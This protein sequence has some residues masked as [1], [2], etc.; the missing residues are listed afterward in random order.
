MIP[1]CRPYRMGVDRFVACTACRATVN[2]LT[3][4]LRE[5]YKSEYDEIFKSTAMD[6]CDRL[7][8]QTPE[9]CS[10]MIDL[11]MPS[12]KYIIENSK[13]DAS[14]FC[15]LFMELNFCQV[16]DV[17]YNWTLNVD[18]G[19]E[20]V[21]A[22]KSE[23]PIKNGNELR[24]LH[25]TDIHYDPLYEP[26][27]LAECDEPQCCQR[28]GGSTESGKAAGYWGDY[29]G[30]DSP[31]HMIVDALKHIKNTHSY[32]DYIYQTGDVVDHMTWATSVE[33]NT[34]VLS[35]VN[36]LLAEV[37]PGVPVYSCVGN[38]EAH[39][40]NLFSPDDVSKEV[41]TH[42]L[43]EHL[44]EDWSEWLPNDTKNTI[45]AG[46][47]YTVTPKPGFRVIALNN[48]D[49][50]TENWWLFYDGTNKIPQLQWLHDTLLAAEKASE[51]VHILEHIQTGDETCWSVW[52]REFNRLVERFRYT[53]SGI[54]NGHSHRDEMHLHYS[55][56]G[57]AIGV[58]WNGGALTTSSSKNPN[59]RIYQLEHKTLQVVDSETWIFNLTE[60][61]AHGE[62]QTPNWSKEYEFSAEFTTDLSPE[63]MDKLLDKMADNPKLLR[64]FWRYK[65]T[66]ADPQLN[67]GCNRNCL[68]NTIC[69]IAITVNNQKTR[70]EQLKAKLSI[71]LANEGTTS[72][73]TSSTTT[74]SAKTTTEES[75]NTT[76]R[77][78]DDAAPCLNISILILIVDGV[79][80]VLQIAEL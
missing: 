72:S 65:V 19:G 24:I 28:G 64:K 43:Y 57:H 76:D 26:G 80:L 8:L 32:I 60:A 47:Y 9:V 1:F 68:L 17:N 55:S 31:W 73:I 58:T 49:C 41:N 36:K 27:S 44:Y 25:L 66:S 16:K 39:P 74:P 23:A 56:N 53:I 63:G 33:K 37:F 67:R 6:I 13:A 34:N 75:N 18:G 2:V 3:R 14:T 7:H 29:R 62:T 20:T 42:W 46:G 54:F 21:T 70:C 4:T 69:R 10:G 30:C 40:V 51:F 52:S 11:Y 38:H 79:L 15:S 78:L 59:Y 5:N 45:L 61:N 50:L 12:A 71:S 22:P 48:N 35:K 77:A